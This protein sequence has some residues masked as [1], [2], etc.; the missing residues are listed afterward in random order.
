MR[1]KSWESRLQGQ[2]L[3]KVREAT[4]QKH[5]WASVQRD[6]ISQQNHVESWD[7]ETLGITENWNKI[8]DEYGGMGGGK[9]HLFKCYKQRASYCRT[10]LIFVH[11]VTC[12]T[13]QYQGHS[14]ACDH[15]SAKPTCLLTHQL[16]RTLVQY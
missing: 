1:P 12:N 10:D 8:W 4:A 6:S 14:L 11:F 16:C 13:S 3:C 9:R 2:L 15:P 5:G 7:L